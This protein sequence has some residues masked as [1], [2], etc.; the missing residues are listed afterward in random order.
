[1]KS[2]LVGVSGS[3]A[4]VVVER[5]GRRRKRGVSERVSSSFRRAWPAPGSRDAVTPG[6]GREAGRG[7]SRKADEEIA[8]R[9][10][11]SERESADVS[12]AMDAADET[13]GEG[14]ERAGREAVADVEGREGRREE[15]LGCREST[16]DM[17]QPR[18][19]ADGE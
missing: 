2:S 3:T 16:H 8:E 11:R 15:R 12:S 1:V 10:D 18:S 7:G 9:R 4:S 17:T 6:V 14:T 19:A 13:P 5:R